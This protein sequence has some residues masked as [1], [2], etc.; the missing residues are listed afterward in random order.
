M[1]RSINGEKTIPSHYENSSMT[2]FYNSKSYY[3]VYYN[4][5]RRYGDLSRTYLLLRRRPGDRDCDPPPPQPQRVSFDIF[6]IGD[7]R[8]VRVEN[9][10]IS[11]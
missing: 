2:I 4:D 8:I 7:T 9:P 11:S 1:V 6:G 3:C 5:A 10:I